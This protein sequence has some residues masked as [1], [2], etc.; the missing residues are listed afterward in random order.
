MIVVLTALVA[1]VFAIVVVLTALVVL[2]F[3][4]STIVVLGDVFLV[5][6]GVHSYH[7][8]GS[9]V[10]GLLNSGIPVL[11]LQIRGLLI[12]P[13]A[14]ASATI[15]DQMT[16]CAFL[17]CYDWCEVRALD[18]YW[19]EAVVYRLSFIIRHARGFARVAVRT[20]RYRAGV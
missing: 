4:V 19:C 18:F 10:F 13:A 7:A 2:G 3:V 15:K 16:I 11:L 17:K 1:I 5:V 12:A 6:P 20:T 14:V 9:S 8:Q